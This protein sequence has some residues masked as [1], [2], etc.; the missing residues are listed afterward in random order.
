MQERGQGAAL[1]REDQLLRADILGP[2]RV[3]RREL[4]HGKLSRDNGDTRTHR[5]TLRY[6]PTSDDQGARKPAQ[7][8][9]QRSPAR[10]NEKGRRC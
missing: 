1:T 10:D 6:T 5:K 8:R 9:P 3:Q 4:R 2:Q 7:R